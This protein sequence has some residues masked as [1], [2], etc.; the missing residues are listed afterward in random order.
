MSSHHRTHAHT[1]ISICVMNILLLSFSVV[2]SH[3]NSSSR[4]AAFLLLMININTGAWESF[5]VVVATKWCLF[6]QYFMSHTHTGKNC[7]SLLFCVKFFG[8]FHISKRHRVENKQIVHHDAAC[9]TLLAA[10]NNVRT[11]RINHI[12]E[13][14]IFSDIHFS[15]HRLKVV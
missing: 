9:G 11:L 1:H 6:G 3:L 8:A 4:R 13:A 7:T 14:H 5:R 10:K 15:S 2:F 12:A